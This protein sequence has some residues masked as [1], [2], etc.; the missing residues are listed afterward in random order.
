[1]ADWNKEWQ[2]E[3]ADTLLV[4]RRRHGRAV[5]ID[6]THVWVTG[7]IR[8]CVDVLDESE[9]GIGILL[10]PDTS[11]AFGPEVHVDYLGAHRVT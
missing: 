5:P 7:D 9:S 6:G 11:F 1:M 8:V 3:E 10:P 2:P 4:E